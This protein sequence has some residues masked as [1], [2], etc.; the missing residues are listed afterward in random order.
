MIAYAVR[1]E[2]D[3]SGAAFRAE[4]DDGRGNVARAYR[5]HEADAIAAAWVGYWAKMEACR[6]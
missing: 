6:E 5:H 2:F 3:L 4:V 1:V